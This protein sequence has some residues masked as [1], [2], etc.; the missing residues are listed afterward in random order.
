MTC[1][2]GATSA[3]SAIPRRATARIP[4][5]CRTRRSPGASCPRTRRSSSSNPTRRSWRPWSSPACCAAEPLPP[6]SAT[7]E[8]A[9]SPRSWAVDDA[10][11]PYRLDAW[12]D[13]FF[14]INEAGH[15]AVHPFDDQDLG[16]DVL[17]VVEEAGRRGI[18]FPLLLRFQDVLRTR[19]R[20]LNQ[21]FGRAIEDCGYR[22]RYTGVYPIK[23]N[24]LHEVVDEVLDAGRQWNM[25]L[26]C[27]SKAELVAALP[28]LASDDTLL[29]CNGVKDASMLSL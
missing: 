3:R 25:G 5:P 2:A 22:N 14:R 28:Q 27:G 29:I 6:V 8:E 9:V 11:G 4:A 17:D 16:I 12:G 7:T 15:I 10:G 19:V 21:A 18:D 26:E 24:Q 13:G 20:R 1:P 23:V